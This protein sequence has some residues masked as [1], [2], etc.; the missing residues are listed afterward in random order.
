MSWDEL[1]YLRRYMAHAMMEHLACG[2]SLPLRLL[3]SSRS[4]LRA[5]VDERRAGWSGGSASRLACEALRRLEGRESGSA[6]EEAVTRELERL[7]GILSQESL[8]WEN[9]LELEAFF[10]QV[11]QAEDERVYRRA[12]GGGS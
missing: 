12:C 1:T 9:R 8:S 10:D 5:A 6:G 2:E 4:F 11:F 7:H 3:D